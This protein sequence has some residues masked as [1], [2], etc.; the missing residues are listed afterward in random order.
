MHFPN[1]VNF[2]FF[3]VHSLQ[4]MDLRAMLHASE[5]LE[6]Q[7]CLQVEAQANTT[8]RGAMVLQGILSE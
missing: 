8:I 6:V 1:F 2:T 4:A 5:V 3:Q 7:L